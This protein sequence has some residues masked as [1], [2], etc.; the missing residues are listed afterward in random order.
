MHDSYKATR[1]DGPLHRRRLM[2]TALVGLSGLATAGL[3]PDEVIA[4]PATP[5]SGAKITT[6]PIKPKIQTSEILI[7]LVRFS[8]PS[9]TAAAAP[10]ALLNYLYHDGN[11]RLFV[12]DS[13][14]PIWQVDP[15]NGGTL[16]FFDLAV[17]R[18]GALITTRAGK[19]N[20]VGVRS[21]AFH[22]NFAQSGKPGFRKFYTA[23]VE[24]VAGA[25]LPCGTFPVVHHSV[26]AEWTVDGA[27]LPI[28][29]S[30]RELLRTAHWQEAHNLDTLIF[31]PMSG[32]LL[33]TVGDGGN[34]PSGPD[35][36]NAGQNRAVAL[37]KILRINPLASGARPYSVPSDNPFVGRSGFLPEIWAYGLRHP[38]YV[39]FDPNDGSLG[40]ISDIGQARVEEV[41]ILAK[42]ANYGWS[43]REGTFVTDRADAKVL[44]GLPQNDATYKFRYPVVQYDHDEG[45]AIAGGYVY[46]GSAVP[47][48]AGHYLFGDIVKGR[49]FH[50]PV[51]SLVQGSQAAPKELRLV[52]G[53]REVT[54]LGLVGAAN[55]RVDLRFGQDESGE[56]YIM[57]KQEGVIYRIRAA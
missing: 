45:E 51:A 21:F 36:Y 37:G 57:T 55:G 40:L 38:Q 25:T 1:R 6:N 23:T 2:Q 9:A 53:G 46:R 13:R 48:L 44:Y 54:L 8:T 29:S 43:K 26:V 39:C 14:G 35:P 5:G 50:V 47:A 7:E 34:R 15:S 16:L 24:H 31:D 12:A 42:G 52:K 49:V 33:L 4:A 10:R 22:P 18:D 11:G 27:G 41:N 28:P 56:V 3:L 30:R 17:A 32:H 19:V 20:T